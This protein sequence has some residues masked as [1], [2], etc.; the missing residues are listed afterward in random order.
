MKR[1]IQ[2]FFVCFFICQPISHAQFFEM[3]S[4]INQVNL[5]SYPRMLGEVNGKLLFAADDGIV[6]DELWS[7]DGTATGT[8]LVKDINVPNT[9]IGSNIWRPYKF[10]GLLYFRALHPSYSNELWVSDGTAAGTNLVID[11]NPNGIGFEGVMIE[12]NGKLF[13]G[14]DDG[15]HGME[16]WSTDGTAAGTVLIKDINPGPESAGIYNMVVFDGKLFFSAS[17]GI[18]GSDLELWVSDGTT[19]GTQLFKDINPIGASHVE[20]Y[21]QVGNKLFFTAKDGMHGRE[22]WVTDGSPNGT[23]MVKDIHPTL[24]GVVN[25]SQSMIAFN[26]QIVFVGVD[27]VY[28]NELWISDGTAAG[29]QMI[30]DINTSGGSGVSYITELSGLLYFAAYDGLHGKELWVSDGTTSGTQL[31]KDI[32]LDTSSNPSYFI[33]Y[34]GKLYFSADTST[35]QWSRRELW[36]TDGTAAGT[37]QVSQVTPNDTNYFSNL[38]MATFN[39][40]LFF[41]AAIDSFGFELW[42]F[43]EWASGLDGVVARIKLEIYPNPVINELLISATDKIVSAELINILGVKQH[44]LKNGNR[45]DVGHLPSGLYVINCRTVNGYASGSFLKK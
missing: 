40:G 27:T 6:G 33:S 36:A 23:Q 37:F 29:T 38:P 39:G 16:L 22:L 1:Y 10:N 11:L 45:I 19:V 35:T 18:N 30:K 2:L 43:T 26:N 12:F 15:V 34:N 44:C 28:G 31:L 41:Q 3:M 4:D 32:N 17:D 9:V 20:H 42:K 14:G 7:T 24:D 21:T 8:Q 25:V 13:F 5:G